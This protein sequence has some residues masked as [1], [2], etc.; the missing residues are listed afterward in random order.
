MRRRILNDC[1]D[2]FGRFAFAQRA[3]EES[4]P[5]VRK[6][7]AARNKRENPV[8][9]IHFNFGNRVHRAC[10][11]LGDAFIDCGDFLRRERVLAF[12]IRKDPRLEDAEPAQEMNFQR[13]ILL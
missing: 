3:A 8:G 2:G 7:V 6:L 5:R 11:N 12:V 13:S 9:G 4:E 10:A 1:R